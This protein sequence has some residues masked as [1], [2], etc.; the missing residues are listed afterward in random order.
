MRKAAFLFLLLVSGSELLQAQEPATVYFIRNTGVRGS[1]TAF[2]AFI[3][4][5]FVCRLNSNRYSIHEIEPGEHQ[6]TVQYAGKRSKKGAEVIPISI[7]GGKTYYVQMTMKTGI[8]LNDLYCVELTE[9]TAV[10]LLKDMKV[11]K[12]CKNEVVAP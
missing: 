9:Q 12:N 7:E 5:K 1:A 11:D 8:L 2:N 3:D 6:F 10:T 4:G